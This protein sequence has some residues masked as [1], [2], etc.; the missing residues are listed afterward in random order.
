MAS[1]PSKDHKRVEREW[2][3]KA[4]RKEREL[5]KAAKAKKDSEAKLGAEAEKE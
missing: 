2:R 4:K 5:A 3:K 1:T